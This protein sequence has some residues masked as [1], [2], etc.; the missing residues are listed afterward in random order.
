M[1]A[2]R[3][4]HWRIPFPAPETTLPELASHGADVD[5][6]RTTLPPTRRARVQAFSRSHTGGVPGAVWAIT[7]C[8]LGLLI[9]YSLLYPIYIGFDEPQHVD[10]TIALRHDPLSWPDPGERALSQSV[11]SSQ[12]IIS[13]RVKNEHLKPGLLPLLGPYQ[14]A[15]IPARHD[16]KTIQ[17]LG[18]NTP[19][20]VPPALPNQMVQH[21]PLYYAIGAATL[22]V[23]PYSESLAYDQVVSILR[24]I[25]ILM[26][27][28]LPLLIWATTRRLVG[29][30]PIAIAASALPLAVPGL[31]RG[32]ANYQ[33]DNLLVLAVAVLTLLLVKVMTGDFSRRTAVFVGL[34]MSAALLTKGTALPLTPLVPL[35]YAAG[36]WRKRGRFPMSAAVTAC[37]VGAI[38][39]LWWVRNLLVFKTV[40]VNGYGASSAR[41]AQMQNANTLPHPAQVW[42]DRFATARPGAGGWY[43]WRFWSGLGVLDQNGLSFTVFRTLTIVTVIGVLLALVF[44]FGRGRGDRAAA[45][46]LAL[47]FFLITAVVAYGAYSEYRRTGISG[48]I[49]GRYAYPAVPALCALVAI[50]YGRLVGLVGRA[51]R[52]VRVLPALAFLAVLLVQAIALRGIVS[53]FWMPRTIPDRIDRYNGALRAIAAWSPWPVG[54]TYSAFVMTTILFVFAFVTVVLP[55]PARALRHRLGHRLGHRSGNHPRPARPEVVA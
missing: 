34:A 2:L 18:D 8:Y 4:V 14:P 26:I 27:A 55:G 24:L 42:L 19:T 25:S 40:Q 5:P 9:C 49:Q 53:G 54:V 22:D 52:L 10:M 15:E 44:G 37:A 17:Q 48:G 50:G 28:P 21:P 7:A 35:A 46:V 51:W 36:W 45:G 38:G 6:A 33:N 20:A 39:G 1:R 30:G 16:R 13:S 41:L 32:A 23:L 3:S 11:A 47:P 29:E 43:E 31:A 12:S